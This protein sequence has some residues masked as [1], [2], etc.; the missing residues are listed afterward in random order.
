MQKITL[1]GKPYISIKN[2]W[3][4]LDSVK[5]LTDLWM[6]NKNPIEAAFDA[7]I[8]HVWAEELRNCKTDEDRAY[9]LTEPGDYIVFKG[10][11]KGEFQ[12]FKE[13]SEKKA[14]LTDDEQQAMRF[15][16][17]DMAEG[18]AAGLGEGW[19]TIDMS[20]E[21]RY[22]LR[23]KKENLFRLLDEASDEEGTDDADSEH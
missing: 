18:V 14:V 13:F 1:N 17:R 21:A 15:N 23:R 5:E 12:Y 2:L 20:P 10:R 22:E 9:Y 7:V 4:A 8:H 6:K 11:K 3:I 16:Y 19:D